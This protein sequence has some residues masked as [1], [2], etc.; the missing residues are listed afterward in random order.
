MLG[1]AKATGSAAVAQNVRRFCLG[2]RYFSPALNYHMDS[3]NNKTNMEW[4]FTKPNK[5]GIITPHAMH[6]ESLDLRLACNNTIQPSSFILMKQQLFP[7]TFQKS[8][9]ATHISSRGHFSTMSRRPPPTSKVENAKVDVDFKSDATAAQEVTPHIKTKRLD[10]TARHIMQI[11]EKEAVQSVK[12]E[13]VIPDIKPG[14]IIELKV[15]VPENKRRVSTLKGIVI[16]KRNAGLSTT[17]RIRRLVAGIGVESVFPLYSPNIKQIKVLDKKRVRRAKLYYLREKMGSSVVK[18][19][20]VCVL[21]RSQKPS[22]KTVWHENIFV[23][24]TTITAVKPT[25]RKQSGQRY[26]DWLPLIE[27][28]IIRS[29][30]D[31]HGEAALYLTPFCQVEGYV[32]KKQ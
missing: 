16:A 2:L 6:E 32:T 27:D 31:I 18:F 15:E 29:A 13:R 14:Y 30:Q 9:I 23:A 5:E 21:R 3:P 24:L 12:A 17:F 10:K 8:L 28:C 26:L 1:L 7:T 4:E 19:V 20:E 25:N 11:L 22:T